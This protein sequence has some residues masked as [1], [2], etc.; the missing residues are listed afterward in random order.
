MS[1]YRVK[2]DI[3]NGPMDLLLYLIRRNEVDIHDIPIAQ[4]TKQYVEYVEL[5]KQFD[6]DLA[7]EFLVMAATL[8][9]IKSALLLPRD[10]VEAG[11]EGEDLSDPRLELVRQLLEYKKFKDVAGQLEESA[12]LQENRFPRSQADLDRLLESAR[13]EQ[14]LDLESIQIW[15]L[16]DA[17]TSLMK[18]TLIGRREHQVYQDDTP[19]DL[20][21]VDILQRAQTQQPLTFAAVFEGRSSKIEM[22]GLF[23]ALLELIRQKLLRIEQEKTFGDIYLFPL[24]QESP[25]H[26]VAN[27]V[28]ADIEQLPSHINRDKGRHQQSE[29]EA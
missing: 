9:E 11:E 27:A 19:I 15:D 17:F 7:G 6:I 2:L 8:M 13:Q 24:T 29:P 14:Q 10:T 22:V 1:D 12:H 3:Y 26:A 23:L 4:I 16:F 25:E 21:E 28:S 5:I 20:Y 18:A